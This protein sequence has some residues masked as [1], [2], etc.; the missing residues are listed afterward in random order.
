M[1][2]LELAVDSISLDL[3]V[4]QLDLDDW[5]HEWLIENRAM[6]EEDVRRISYT[7][8]ALRAICLRAREAEEVLKAE[9][10]VLDPALYQ[11]EDE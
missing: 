7:E 1:S 10:G 2:A 8:A 3:I 6:D 9:Y 4:E 11:E 5:L